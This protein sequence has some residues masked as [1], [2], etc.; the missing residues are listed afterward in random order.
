MEETRYLECIKDGKIIKLPIQLKK[1]S[2]RHKPTPEERSRWRTIE[3]A[4]SMACSFEE[5]QEASMSYEVS[6]AILKRVSNFYPVIKRE[7]KK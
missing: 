6:L 1:E 5:Q 7:M 3:L 2:D 4:E